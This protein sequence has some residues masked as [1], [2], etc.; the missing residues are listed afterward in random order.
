MG[1]GGVSTG[2][3]AFPTPQ[4]MAH[5]QQIEAQVVNSLKLHEAWEILDALKKMANDENQIGTLKALLEHYPQ[6]VS[7][8]YELEVSYPRPPFNHSS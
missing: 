3:N 1:L 2:F 5:R 6:L 4:Q 7:A 8:T